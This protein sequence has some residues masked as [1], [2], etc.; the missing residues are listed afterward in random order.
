MKTNDIPLKSPIKLQ[1]EMQKKILNFSKFVRFLG[2]FLKKQCFW[3]S[4]RGGFVWWP[5]LLSFWLQGSE[6][7]GF[8][9][10]YHLYM[11]HKWFGLYEPPKLKN[12]KKRPF[13]Y[14]KGRFFW[15]FNFD[16]SDSC[17]LVLHI[18]LISHFKALI[19]SSLEAEGQEA[20]PPNKAAMPTFP[21][22][23]LF[24]KWPKNLTNFGKFNFFFAFLVA[25]L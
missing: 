23:L 15:S 25:I 16:G 13:S 7:Q 11:Y 6:Y 18:Q 5:G 4:E 8:K 17:P 24:Q 9:M 1:G 21:K 14:L 20:W 22:T 19:F 2:H 10:K 12:R 3:K